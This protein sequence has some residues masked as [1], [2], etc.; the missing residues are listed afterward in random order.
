MTPL[1]AAIF[2][3]SLAGSTHCAGMCGA[4]L[5]FAVAGEPVPAQSRAMLHVAYHGGRLVTYILLGAVAGVI[6]RA[7]DLSAADMGVARGAMIVAGALMM[8]FGSVAALSAAGVRLARAPLPPGLS[9]L[10][11]A[12]HRAVSDWSPV[13][14]A[15]AIGL[16]T[17]LLPCGWLYAFAISA[18]GTGDWKL[19]ALTMA[20][21]W[22]GTLPVMISLGAGLHV[23]GGPL[24]RRLP[25]LTSVAM[26]AVGA[27]TL[28]GRAALPSF[29]ST[30]PVA[31]RDIS[32]VHA[33]V[34]G[35][36]AC[37]HGR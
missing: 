7:I 35:E 26:L 6:G 15:A 16:L 11:G 28:A 8:V 27:W 24:R 23:L 31:P 34:P 32:A 21:F 19:G 12:G 2:V 5:A 10:V 17:T 25:V 20:V 13:N 22:L 30:S 29:A 3:A 36:E 4:F 33:P 14:R 1:I 37:C 9:R 18:A